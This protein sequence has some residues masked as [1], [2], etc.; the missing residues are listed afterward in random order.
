MNFHWHYLLQVRQSIVYGNWQ[1]L[2]LFFS[3][4]V[5]TPAYDCKHPQKPWCHSS[6]NNRKRLQVNTEDAPFKIIIVKPNYFRYSSEQSSLFAII[7][8]K[9]KIWQFLVK[10]TC[11]ASDYKILYCKILSS[12]FIVFR[13]SLEALLDRVLDRVFYKIVWTLA[14]IFNFSVIQNNIFNSLQTFKSPYS[15]TCGRLGLIR[16]FAVWRTLPYKGMK[17]AR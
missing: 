9:N 14:K 6:Y 11:N 1:I 17:W 5:A 3:I 4:E 2:K 8:I 13:Y 10:M 12:I 7:L 15:A 16:G